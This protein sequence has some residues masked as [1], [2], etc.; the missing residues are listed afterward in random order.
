VILVELG[1]TEAW[2]LRAYEADWYARDG[3]E[4]EESPVAEVRFASV[5]RSA[6]FWPPLFGPAL[7]GLARIG[8]VVVGCGTSN[9]HCSSSK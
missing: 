4:G 8:L 9:V 7:I 5:V 1:P 3:D 2:H 6:D